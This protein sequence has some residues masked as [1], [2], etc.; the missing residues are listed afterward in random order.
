MTFR[1]SCGETWRTAESAAA[2]VATLI[3]I[4]P[5]GSNGSE[6]ED[7]VLHLV[8]VALLE[9]VAVGL[10]PGDLEARVVAVEPEGEAT[11]RALLVRPGHRVEILA[12]VLHVR[13]DLE[14]VE[15]IAEL[16]HRGRLL[17]ERGDED[18][19]VHLLIVDL[20]RDTVTAGDRLI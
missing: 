4:S 17:G 7:L 9:A 1:S 15:E 10:R 12:G 6:L 16:G 11:L 14:G 13:L 19:A 20:Q 2:G 18:V 8:L 5:L 3:S